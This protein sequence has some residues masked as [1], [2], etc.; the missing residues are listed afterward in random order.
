MGWAGVFFGGIKPLVLS[1]YKDHLGFGDELAGY[2]VATEISGNVIGALFVASVIHS[3]D[4]RAL[5]ITALV[6]MLLGNLA[7]LPIDVF[8]TLIGV[9]FLVGCGEGL[10]MGVMS[11]TLAGTTEPDRNFAIYTAAMLALETIGFIVIPSFLNVFGMQGIF[12]LLILVL[13]PA[14]VTVPFFPRSGPSISNGGRSMHKLHDSPPTGKIVVVITGAFIAYLGIGGFT[15]FMGEI[16]RV[17]GIDGQFRA[18]VLAFVQFCGFLGA[19]TATWQGLRWGR[20]RPITIALAAMATSVAVVLVTSHNLAMF[21]IAMPVFL[22]MWLYFFAYLSGV[23][24][25]LDPSGRITTLMFTMTSV[26]FAVGPAMNGWLAE[27]TNGYT[28]VE[29]VTII[30]LLLSIVFLVPIAGDQDRYLMIRSKES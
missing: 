1:A 8:S 16:G 5:G 6:L 12:I 2:L 18:N 3:W 4:R 22:F 21:I 20:R 14:F 19:I 17:S 15:P 29:F 11:G 30:F 25:A 13:V 23:T 24:S 7:S 27:Y 28:A 26:G 9:R 10:A